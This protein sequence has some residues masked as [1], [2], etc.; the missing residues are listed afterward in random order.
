VL[1]TIL[2]YEIQLALD[3]NLTFH[4]EHAS[5]LLDG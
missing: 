3:F 1:V 4:I 2:R 5:S